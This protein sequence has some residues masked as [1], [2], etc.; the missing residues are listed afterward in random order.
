MKQIS[1]STASTGAISS[2]PR[3][4]MTW[5]VT[6]GMMLL[7]GTPVASAEQTATESVRNTMDEVIHILNSEELN[8]PGRSVERRQ[9]IEHVI[10]QGV[11]YEDMAKRALGEPWI[12]LTDTERQEFVTLFVQLLRDTFAGRIDHYADEQVRYLSEQYEENCAEVR[13]RLSGRKV[14][15]LLDFR[16]VDKIGHWYVYDVVIDGAG[17]VSNY[18]AQFASIIRTHSYIGLVN[19]MKEKTLVVKAFETTTAP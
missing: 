14:D 15:T 16:L 13:V 3:L 11:S 18:H 19:K 7:I 6:V 8:Q 9:K 17:I 5:V 4:G 12:E 2:E 1:N 10:R